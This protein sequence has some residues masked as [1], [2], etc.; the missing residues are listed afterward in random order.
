MPTRKQQTHVPRL[1]EHLLSD[2]LCYDKTAN[3][4]ESHLELFHFLIIKEKV[5][6]HWKHENRV[7]RNY[8]A[9]DCYRGQLS[10]HL[11]MNTKY[12]ENGTELKMQIKL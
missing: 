11:Y 2:G 8:R 7:S 5:K 12:E 3:D 4:D 1:E 9:A 6:E 10:F